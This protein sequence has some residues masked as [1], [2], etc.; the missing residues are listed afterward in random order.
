[1][2]RKRSIS[3]GLAS[4]P[5]L[6]LSVEWMRDDDEEPKER[7]LALSLR[8]LVEELPFDVWVLDV[9]DEVIFANATA[10][11]NWGKSGERGR[12]V[13]GAELESSVEEKWRTNNARALA[14]E[15]VRHEVVS[16]EETT[17]R[18]SVSS[19]PFAMRAASWALSA[20]TST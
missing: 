13:E 15:T 18:S 19:R 17:A 5:D 10:R 9:D 20:S 6:R 11:K 3:M 7:V 16:T 4:S 8:T 14:G 2:V 1:M 12:T